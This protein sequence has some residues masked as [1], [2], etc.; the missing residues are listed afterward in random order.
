MAIVSIKNLVHKYKTHN[1]VTDETEDFT[2]VDG[3]SLEVNKGEFIAI[4]GHNGSGKSTLA[5][6][7][8]CLLFPTEGK[9]Y[10]NEKDTSLEDNVLSIRTEAGMVFQNPDNQI[11]ATVVEEDVAFGPENIGIETSEIRIRVDEALR[12]V[13]MQNFLK[14][15]PNRLSG[16]QKQRVAIAGVLAMRPQCIILDEPT[17][18]LDPEGRKEVLNTIK[19]L[20]K[21]N[22]MTVILVTHHMDEV[23]DAD[24][25]IVMKEGRIAENGTPRE[26]IADVERMK[27]LSLDVPQVTEISYLICK[28]LPDFGICLTNAEFHRSMMMFKNV[29]DRLYRSMI[30][31][32]K[33]IENFS[34]KEDGEPILSLNNVSYVYDEKTIFSNKVLK[35]INLNIYRNEYLAV[36]GHTGSGKSTLIQ[37]LNSL[38]K[39]SEGRVFYH[40]DDIWSEG[41]DRKHVRNGVGLVFQYPDHQLFEMSVLKD[42]MFGPVNQGFDSETAEM[43]AIEALKLVGVD[44]SVWNKSP[45]DLSGGQ[46]KRV[47]IAGVLAMKPEII[48]LDEPTA[49][50]DP[51]G[52]NEILE[53]I[54][55]IYKKTAISVVLVSHSMEDVAKYADRIVVMDGGAILFDDLPVN[56]FNNEKEL[57]KAGL[58]VPQINSALRRL[59]A[60]DPY[61]DTDVITMEAYISKAEILKEF[62]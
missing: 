29:S 47:S 22:G 38:I 42:V 19:K 17:A 40:D 50:L 31:L 15:S 28:N 26:L 5:R 7:I 57:K 11:V 51:L 37:Q 46:K 44:E 30:P 33:K 21:E 10:V 43:R 36:I 13:N 55:D 52:R 48:I 60:T 32:R 34:K 49:G 3:V 54:Y 14:S 20:N 25:L 35:N 12:S 9:V 61:V 16:G 56:V 1:T 24:R 2:A 8:N 23:V 45:F 58:S 41:Y 27:E 62:R 6:H 4:L 53:A 39:P 59:G 18:M